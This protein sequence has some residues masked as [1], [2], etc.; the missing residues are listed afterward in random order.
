MGGK[1]YRCFIP[2]PNGWILLLGIN[3]LARSFLCVHY[4]KLHALISFHASCDVYDQLLLAPQFILF[5][6]QS[7]SSYNLILG[8]PTWHPPPLHVH[9]LSSSNTPQKSQTTKFT[10]NNN[11]S[12]I[13]THPNLGALDGINAEALASVAARRA[14]F[15]FLFYSSVIIK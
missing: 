5:S 8:H 14:T 9:S 15:I 11:T 10:N 1:M 13:N 3:G 6:S 2:V 4:S 7:P 12:H